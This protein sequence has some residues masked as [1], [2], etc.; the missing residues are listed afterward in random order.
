M[1]IEAN[2][3]VEPIEVV[4]V[5]SQVA[6]QINSFGED[7]SDPEK[8]VSYRSAVEE[9]TVL[10]RLDDA[11]F[12]ARVEQSRAQ[13]ERAKADVEQAEVKAR[14]THRTLERQSRLRSRGGGLVSAE[15]YDT[16]QAEYE[17]ATAALTVAQ[18]AVKIAEANMREAQVNLDYT[19]IRS[20]V[21]GVV[22]DRRVNL[23]QTVSAGL[24]GSSLFLIARDLSRLE[25]WASVNEAD[26]GE[27]HPGQA[28]RFS[29][30][31]FPER[32]FEGKVEQIRLN[33]SMVHNVV[34]YTVVV[35]VDN[36][37]EEL[38]PYL[39]ARV[40]FQVDRR[41]DVLLVP[42]AALRFRPA[43]KHVAPGSRREKRPDERDGEKPGRLWVRTGEHLR[44]ISVRVGASDGLKTEVEGDD[45][46]EGLEVV[47]GLAVE[48]GPTNAS[49]FLPQFDAKKEKAN[50]AETPKR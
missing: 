3:T 49:P 39:T 25:I 21:S 8:S 41:A 31:A 43:A 11:L 34:T 16:A 27:I 5:G 22:L 40:K 14:Q 17:A 28:V 47:V 35:A 2:G 7:P 26:I 15:E 46:R 23:G 33:A 37:E 6:G 20:P 19:T 18:S 36:T 45:L 30:S 50:E 29:V 48:E 4:D 1:T 24:S 32:T 12:R 38:L 13:L 44:P 10:A 42:N 9:G